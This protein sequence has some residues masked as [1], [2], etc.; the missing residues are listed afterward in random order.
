MRFNY[1]KLSDYWCRRAG[2][3]CRC[4][5]PA[6]QRQSSENRLP[7]VQ[8]IVWRFAGKMP[9]LRRNRKEM[10]IKLNE[11]VRHVQRV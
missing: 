8:E 11:T 10:E 4:Y 2:G 3:D 5:K 7:I 6:E 1:V 9:V